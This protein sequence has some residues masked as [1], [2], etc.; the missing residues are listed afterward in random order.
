MEKK[1]VSLLLEEKTKTC[2]SLR[3]RKTLGIL[4]FSKEIFPLKKTKRKT[5]MHQE[6]NVRDYAR[7]N[8]NHC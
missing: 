3:K 2:I 1:R 5:S 7:K 8:F 4:F 6:R